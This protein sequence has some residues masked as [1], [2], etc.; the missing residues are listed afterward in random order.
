MQTAMLP[1]TVI[2][3]ARGNGCAR[4]HLQ[5][6]AFRAEETIPQAIGLLNEGKLNWP[7]PQERIALLGA[8]V[9]SGHMPSAH[10]EGSSPTRADFRCTMSEETGDEGL[11]QDYTTVTLDPASSAV[12]VNYLREST[13]AATECHRVNDFYLLGGVLPVHAAPVL[14]YQPAGN[15]STTTRRERIAAMAV[16]YSRKYE[17]FLNSDLPMHTPL[18]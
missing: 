7:Y 10:P 16:K 14:L 18:L 15:A 4:V 12:N 17:R 9:F 11:K 6:F 13:V 5:V 2:G 1:F 8:A 3:V